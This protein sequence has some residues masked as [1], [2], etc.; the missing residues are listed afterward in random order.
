MLS[1]VEGKGTTEKHLAK[2]KLI[3]SKHLSAYRWERRYV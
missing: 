2:K 1:E 3:I